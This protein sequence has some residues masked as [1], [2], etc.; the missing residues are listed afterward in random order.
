[1]KLDSIGT[2][3]GVLIGLPAFFALFFSG[4]WTAA[5]L[6]LLLVAALIAISWYLSLPE[7]TIIRIE[8]VLTLYDDQGKRSKLVRRCTYRGIAAMRRAQTR[9]TLRGK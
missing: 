9:P 3:I 4:A 1:M 7:F 8:K 2:W 6:V 5:F